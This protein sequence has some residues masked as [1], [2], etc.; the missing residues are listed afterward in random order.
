MEDL[1]MGVL[2]WLIVGLIAGWLAGVVMKGK[3]FGLLG[4]LVIGVIGALV[5]GWLAG[6]I[7]NVSNAISG[8]NL[9]TILIAFLGAVVVLYIA[10]LIK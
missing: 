9:G 5:G 1:K 6:A 4:N 2:T 3:G 7:F 8:F 10:R